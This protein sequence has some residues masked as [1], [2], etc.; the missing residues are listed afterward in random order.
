MVDTPGF[1]LPANGDTP[2]IL[3]GAGTGVAP[4]RAFLQHRANHGQQGNNWLIF[5]SR[6]FHHDFLYQTD[7]QDFRKRGLLTRTSLAFSRD[8]PDKVYV[9]DRLKE[10]GAELYRWLTDGAHLYVCGGTGMARA[11]HKALLDIVGR[12]AGLFEEQAMEY[13]DELRQEGRYQRDVY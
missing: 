4:Y 2:I 13:L 9:Q 5:G 6:Q 11:V 1:R 3:I 10:D 12:E 7:W 8:Q